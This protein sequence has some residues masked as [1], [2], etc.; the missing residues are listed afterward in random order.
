MSALKHDTADYQRAV[1][2]F[3]GREVV[4]CVSTLVSEVAAIEP[5][6]A[7]SN[8]QGT[9]WFHLFRR[10]PDRDDCEDQANIEFREFDG[11]WG[12]K[13]KTD[14]SQFVW[15]ICDDEDKAVEDA[16][17]EHDVEGS[18]VFE[19]WIV[20]DFLARKLA[21]RGEVIERDF[22]GLTI[23]GRTTTGQAISID[24][25]ICQIYGELHAND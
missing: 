12:W 3:V 10:E 24:W 2:E 11:A 20:S 6:I 8:Y 22:Y 18:E 16:A 14:T 13:D 19:H 4:Y 15:T 7:G 5:H 9:E 17:R 1:D 23:W 21:E 25:V